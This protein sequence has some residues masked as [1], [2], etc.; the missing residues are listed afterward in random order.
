[1]EAD[2]QNHEPFKKKVR[3]VRFE[4]HKIPA[5]KEKSRTFDDFKAGLFAEKSNA[6]GSNELIE[7]YFS[8]S[9]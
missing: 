3:A 8:S 1:L 7:I 5:L 4:I 6:R 9:D 2:I